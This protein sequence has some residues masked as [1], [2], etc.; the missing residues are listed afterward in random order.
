MQD[1]IQMIWNYMTQKPKTSL[2]PK[3]HSFFYDK[4]QKSLEL[5]VSCRRPHR[6]LN[7]VLDMIA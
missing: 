1:G 2:V 5:Y 3:Q 7:I 6:T 4:A